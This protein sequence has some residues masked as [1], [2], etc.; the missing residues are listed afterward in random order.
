MTEKP[1]AEYAARNA[2]PIIEIL[3][4]EFRD[5]QS[6]LEI[7]SGTGQHAVTFAAALAHLH[8]QTSDLDANHAGINAWI[9]SSGLDNVRAPLS[10]DV[11]TAE[12]GADSFDAAFSSNT[13]HIM[14]ID[15]V[16]RMYSLIGTALRESGVFCLYGPFRCDGEFNTPSNAGFDADLRGRD[17]EM[18]V[19]DLET[20]DGFA[21]AN[22]LRRLRLYAV[23]SNNYVAVWRKQGARP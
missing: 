4:R 13:A 6:V 7:G 23:P 5:S 22:G 11:R 9:E 16:E 17:P 1:Y 12:L 19:R 15:A 18:G 21:A 2:G 14:G 10:V 20:L 3:E 8:W